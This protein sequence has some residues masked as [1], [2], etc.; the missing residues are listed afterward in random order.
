MRKITI[1]QEVH[2]ANNAYLKI[3]Q[4]ENSDLFAQ[5]LHTSDVLR[6]C[7]VVLEDHLM[8]REGDFEALTVL[9]FDVKDELG[10]DLGE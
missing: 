4:N 5:L 10:E 2:D 9:I 8:H 3:L 6:R 7:L 1:S